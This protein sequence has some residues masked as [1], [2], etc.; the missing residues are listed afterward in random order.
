ML[1][2]NPISEVTKA[3]TPG[4]HHFVNG[5]KYHSKTPRSA[6]VA[7]PPKTPFQVLVMLIR[8][9]MMCLL[10]TCDQRY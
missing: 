7:A 3:I 5:V 9:A 10:E 4:C 6:V 1:P 8:G 2:Q